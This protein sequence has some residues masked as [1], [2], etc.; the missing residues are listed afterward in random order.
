[1]YTAF[2]GLREKPF[3]LVPDPR[4]LFLAESH[5]EALAHLLYGIDQSEGFICVTGEVGTGKTTICRTLLDRLGAETEVAFLFNPSR[6][7]IELLQD[8]S[9]EFGLESAGRSRSEL[10]AELNRFLLQKKM[11]KRRVLLIIDEAQNLSEG[12]LEQVRLL[13]NLETSSSKLIQIL[14]LGQPELDRKLDSKELRQLRQRISVRWG[15]H[16]LTAK[17]TR[18]YVKHRLRVAAGSDREV[19]TDTALREIHRRT[20]GVPRLINVLCDRVLLAGYVA[21]QTKIGAGIVRQAAREIPDARTRFPLSRLRIAGARPAGSAGAR[22]FA[23]GPVFAAGLLLGVVVAGGIALS[24]IAVLRDRLQPLFGSLLAPVDSTLAVA[25]DASVSSAPP[26]LSLIEPVEST[27][28]GAGISGSP[29]SG[30]SVV[31]E[32]PE[33]FAMQTLL[34]VDPARVEEMSRAVEA[35]LA[36]GDF[37]AS[38]FGASDEASTRRDAVNAVLDSWG[39]PEVDSLPVTDELAIATLG[40]RGLV[41][42]ALD[43]AD[44]ETLRGLNHP[45]LLRVRATDETQLRLVA[46]IRLDGD[47]ARIHGVKG[48]GPLWVPVDELLQQWDGEAWVTW[49]DFESIRP[50]LAF[51]EQGHSV[52]WLQGALFELGYYEGAATG[53]FDRATRDGLRAFQRGQKL[54]ADGMAG[55]R[56]RMVLYDLL[57]QYQVPRLVAETD[58]DAG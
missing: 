29:E 11:E 24:S 56:T 4:Y 3:A 25:D 38:R 52:E 1:M 15:L 35:G 16:P 28:S 45:A 49:N 41:T 47:L 57:D 48:A 18:A 14:L 9:A 30:V 2:Y 5:R 23:A 31:I 43:D 40:E 19:F 27:V 46:L 13:S 51:G 32:N 44:L 53:L 37:L 6:S 22:R 54:E 50:V 33:A 8:I 12:T 34:P 36:T 26:M 7:G 20:A 10:S 39:L 58:G 42:M 55:P 17:E 21:R